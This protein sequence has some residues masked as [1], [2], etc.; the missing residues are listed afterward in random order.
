MKEKEVRRQTHCI[1]FVIFFKKRLGSFSSCLRVCYLH[2]ILNRGHCANREYVF[3]LDD[4]NYIKNIY[5]FK[6]I[7]GGKE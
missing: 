3:W 2:S 1:D 5:R 7:C 6:L 4:D